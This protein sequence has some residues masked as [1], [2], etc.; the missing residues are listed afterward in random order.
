MVDEKVYAMKQ[1]ADTFTIV[2]EKV[3]ALRGYRLEWWQ[4]LILNLDTQLLHRNS[5]NW[6]PQIY[7]HLILYKW[8]GRQL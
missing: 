4:R 8:Y 2:W 1:I 5:S 6:N 3:E 7:Y